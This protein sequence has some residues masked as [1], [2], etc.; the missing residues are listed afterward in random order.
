MGCVHNL[1][2]HFNIDCKPT[3]AHPALSTLLH[4]NKYSRSCKILH[5]LSTS[6]KVNV[7]SDRMK[8]GFTN[9]F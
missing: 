9:S 2:L 4:F 5:I 1:L 8:T 3:K 7:I 6:E